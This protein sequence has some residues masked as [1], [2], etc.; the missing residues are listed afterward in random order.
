LKLERSP[1]EAT[2]LLPDY[3]NLKAR[4]MELVSERMRRV[5]SG[6]AGVFDLGEEKMIQEGQRSTLHRED[7]TI[8]DVEI[9]AIR[10]SQTLDVD[11]QSLETLKVSDIFALFDRLA[12]AA[13]QAKAKHAFEV[14]S[15]EIEKVGNVESSKNPM[16]EKLL[17]SLQMMEF[18]FV[19]GQPI[20]PSFV[21]NPNTAPLIAE[22]LKLIHESPEL[23]RRYTAII[24]QKRE[25]FRD[26]EAARKLVE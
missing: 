26:R 2:P 25:Q 15:K 19:G 10:V 13:A 17:S 8:Q 21:V 5:E 24:D 3:P 20:L 14:F 12:L 23:M 6:H 22:A 7:G 4:L 9:K 1:L 11:F 18:D 16:H